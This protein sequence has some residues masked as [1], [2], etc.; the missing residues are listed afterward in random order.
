MRAKL[1]VLKLVGKFVALTIVLALG[2][3][4]HN[5]EKTRSSGFLPGEEKEG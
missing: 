5:Q 4:W 3:V 2:S 1:A